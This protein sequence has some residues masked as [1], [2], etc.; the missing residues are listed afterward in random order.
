MKKSLDFELYDTQYN[1]C[2]LHICVC[3]YE[4]V[5]GSIALSASR[6]Q[7]MQC[8]S[9]CMNERAQ[10]SKQIEVCL[11][12]ITAQPSLHLMQI[13]GKQEAM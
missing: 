8:V 1:L 3:V 11:D 2:A 13:I 7:T 9:V 5:S 10:K 6:S 12:D 4:H